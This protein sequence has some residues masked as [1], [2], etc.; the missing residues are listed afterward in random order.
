MSVDLD[1]FREIWLVDFEFCAPPGERPRVLCLVARELRSGRLVRLWEDELSHRRTAPYPLD[2][3]SLVV[4]YY[5]SAEV[6]CHLALGWPVP[7]RVLDLYVEFRNLSNGKPT[8]CGAGLL[9]ALFHYGLAG[10]ESVDKDEMRDL[11]MR[12]GDYTADERRRL[13]DYCQ[14]DVDALVRLLPAMLPNVDLRRA[15][16]RGRY[17]VTAARIEHEGIPIDGDSLARLRI[18]WPD[19]QR[20]LVERVDA[21]YGVYEGR[22]FKAARW[23]AWLARNNIPWPRLPSGALALDDDTFRQMARA[24]PSVAPIRELRHS[25]G[26]LRLADLAVGSDG[27]NRCL[28]SA[29][30]AK[31]GRNQPSNSKFIFGPSAWLRGLIKPP[32]GH[33]VAY[34]DWSQQEFGVAAALSGDA[35]ML[36]AYE[37]GDPYLAFAIQAGAAPPGATKQ[38]HA[39]VRELYKQCVLAVQYMMGAESLSQR[40][41]RSALEA[42]HLLRRHRETFRDY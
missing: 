29:F 2:D 1:Y 16:Y 8:P 25:L 30:R 38:S 17:M 10:I 6:G 39:E 34:V 42:Q 14:S 11:A 24:H 31:T 3:R 20:A 9:G 4:A 23:E 18:R 32:A 35:K 36:A 15:V 28:L 41:G 37:T 13:L 21:D 12:G 22:T 27:R 40:I 5:A 7:S 26:Q 19:I 33:A